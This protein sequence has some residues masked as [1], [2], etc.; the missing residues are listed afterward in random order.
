MLSTVVPLAD[1]DVP[2]DPEPTLP[3]E[4]YGI[5]LSFC[6]LQYCLSPGIR[7]SRPCA[8]PETC[9]WHEHLY[10]WYVQASVCNCS[11][12]HTKLTSTALP[13]S[14]PVSFVRPCQECSMAP[15]EVLKWLL[16]VP[17]AWYYPRPADI[18]LLPLYQWIPQILL[19]LS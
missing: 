10:K 6:L 17:L 18:R 13:L 5:E 7:R 2:S 8:S 15:K 16:V 1:A 4:F 11:I 14:A 3:N 19:Q 9:I 12:S